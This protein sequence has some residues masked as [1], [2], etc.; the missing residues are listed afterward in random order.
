MSGPWGDYASVFLVSVGLG[1][2]VLLA[3]PLVVAP[4]VWARVLGWHPP[5]DSDL[6]VYFGRCLGA[7]IGVLAV[8][9]LFAAGG[10]TMQG[11]RALVG[12]GRRVLR[13]RTRA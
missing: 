11:R 2:L 10:P 3:I 1:S 9:A 7:L 4:V 5:S 6:T 12:L 13:R 8:A